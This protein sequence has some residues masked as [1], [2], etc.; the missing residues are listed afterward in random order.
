M[1][2]E[3]D[4]PAITYP[5]PPERTQPQRTEPVVVPMVPIG[6][7]DP[8]QRLSEQRRILVNGPLDRDTVTALSAQLMALD[9]ESTRDVEIVINSGGGPLEEI[10]PVLDVVDLMRA[11][12]NTTC[13]GSAAGTAVALVA[14]GTGTRRGASN[15][16][17]C[18][19]IDD[20]Q[21]IEGTTTDIIR[22]AGELDAIRARYVATLVA[23]TGLDED[24]LVADIENGRSITAAEARE[25][26]IVDAVDEPADLRSRRADR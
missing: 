17:I 12:T 5:L 13:V 8:W 18:L 23:K 22:R 7:G 6:G 1:T 10:L 2:F 21:A 19:R 25:L 24:R 11:R 4:H 9:G 26:G 15:A 16:T 14:A 20:R 3:P